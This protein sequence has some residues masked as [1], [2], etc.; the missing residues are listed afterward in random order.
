M[1][2]LTGTP[3]AG[4]P[5]AGTTGT[6]PAAPPPAG[7]TGTPPAALPPGPVPYERFKEVN[8]RANSLESR[9]AQ[10]EAAQR[11]AADQKLADEKKWEDLA[12]QREVELKRERTER[13]RLEVAASKG[14]P[15][16]LA[17]RLQG[18]DRAAMEKDADA[19]LAALADAAKRQAG[20]GVPPPPAGGH[21]APVNLAQLSPEEIRK[22][23]PGMLRQ[24]GQ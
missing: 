10:L 14:V 23:T 4:T 13:L 21:A 15:A 1:A 9:L 7:T 16:A 19:I 20:P 5:P 11:T 24:V 6:P 22:A 17:G 3:P 8:D 2:E 12:K 18:D